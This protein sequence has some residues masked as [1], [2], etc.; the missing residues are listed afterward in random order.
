MSIELKVPSIACSGCLDTVTK[1]IQSVDPTA[2]VTGDAT[3]KIVSVQAQ[4]SEDEIKAAIAAAGHTV[5]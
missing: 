1:A 4:I 5:A 3:T 2:T